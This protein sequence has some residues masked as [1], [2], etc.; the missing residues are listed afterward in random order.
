MTKKEAAAHFGS[1]AALARALGIG[2]AAVGAWIDI[3]IDRQC[4]IEVITT[5]RLQADR[6][7]LTSI[8]VS[9]PVV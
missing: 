5:G 3:P 8:P 7:R 6:S 9:S 1:Q 4:Q 2:K